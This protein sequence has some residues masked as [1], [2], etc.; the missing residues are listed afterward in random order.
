MLARDILPATLPVC[1]EEQDRAAVTALAAHAR[2][3][4]PQMLHQYGHHVVAKQVFE[5][6][7]L[8]FLQK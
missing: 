5:G 2:M 3:S 8:Q 6:V 4:L 7:T 1:V